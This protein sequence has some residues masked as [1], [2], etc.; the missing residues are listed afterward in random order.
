LLLPLA[1][2]G[3]LGRGGEA[4]GAAVV[5]RNGQGDGRRAERGGEGRARRG[6]RRRH[7]CEAWERGSRRGR[8]GFSGSAAGLDALLVASADKSGR[9]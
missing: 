4:A 2:R 6:V 1:A 9:G 7:G 8:H 5:E 3:V